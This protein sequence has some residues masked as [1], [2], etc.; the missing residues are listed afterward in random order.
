MSDANIS[1]T[2]LPQTHVIDVQRAM[3]T[4]DY[5][6]M[7]A[8]AELY[9]DWAL[10]EANLDGNQRTKLIQWST[11]YERI[12][13]FCGASWKASMPEYPPDAIAFIARAKAKH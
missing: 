11:D 7:V 8:L 1:P 12:A 13:A 5:A 3:A 2:T 6:E 9:S 10:N 4:L